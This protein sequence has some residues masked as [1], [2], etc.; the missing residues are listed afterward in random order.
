MPSSFTPRLV[1]KSTHAWRSE[2]RTMK[3]PFWKPKAS[4][5]S[6]ESANGEQG[7]YLVSD[8][9]GKPYRL[10]NRAP[11][12]YTFAANDEMLR[13]QMVADFVAILGTLNIIAGELDR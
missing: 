8:G 10:H 13:G 2:T 5:V 4:M 7:F 3:S 12:F 1:A 6:I 9:T 11:S